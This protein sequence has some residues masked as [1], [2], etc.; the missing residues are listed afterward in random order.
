ML[1]DM[2]MADSGHAW[3]AT[4]A[5]VVAPELLGAPR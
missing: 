1:I 3:V 4:F 5:Q 2:L